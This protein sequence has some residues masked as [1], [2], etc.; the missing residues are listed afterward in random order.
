MAKMYYDKD[1]N[2][3]LIKDLKVAIIGYG[4]QGRG[5]SLCLRDSGI[6]VIVSELEGTP[7]YD[8]ATKDGF[9]VVSAEEA[10]KQAD[11]IHITRSWEFQSTNQLK[12]Y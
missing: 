8:Q 3:N 5:Q 7:N 10:S 4:I 12:S 11:I 6:N 9:S 1:A 2:L